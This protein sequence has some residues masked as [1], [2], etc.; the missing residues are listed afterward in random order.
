MWDGR[1][2]SP[3]STDEERAM[4]EENEIAL[5][6]A[7]ETY[8]KKKVLPYLRFVFCLILRIMFAN[9][10]SLAETERKSEKQCAKQVS[11]GIYVTVSRNCINGCTLEHIQMFGGG[12]DGRSN[13]DP[14]KLCRICKTPSSTFCGSIWTP[15]R[16]GQKGHVVMPLPCVKL[17]MYHSAHA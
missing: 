16:L 5:R 13:H 6:N 17:A 9:N 11:N 12:L 14:Y 10:T 15:V 3:I 7:V 2:P 4:F 1:P 8:M